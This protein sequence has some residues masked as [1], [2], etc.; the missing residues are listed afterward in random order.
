MGRYGKSAI[1]AVELILSTKIHPEQA[2][3]IAT[4]NEFGKDSSLQKKGCPKGAFLGLCEQGMIKGVPLGSYT[5]ST[6]NKRYT[7]RAVKILKQKPYLLEN[8]DRLWFE[9]TGGKQIKQNNQLD[10]VLSL[11][12]KN[13]INI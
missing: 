2:W 5:E 12:N 13:Y 6:E 8:E 10:I 1:E 4:S 11:W 7:V 3:D 9:V